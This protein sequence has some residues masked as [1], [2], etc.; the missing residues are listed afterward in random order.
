MGGKK[1]LISDRVINS[2]YIPP[3][4]SNKARRRRDS[5]L[6]KVGKCVNL[7]KGIKRLHPK[8]LGDT[9]QPPNGFDGSLADFD[10]DTLL[11]TIAVNPTY[12]V[13]IDINISFSDTLVY[14]TESHSGFSDGDAGSNIKTLLL[15]VFEK[16]RREVAQR[17]HADNLHSFPA[18]M[19]KRPC[20]IIWNIYRWLGVGI[21][22]T[23]S[24]I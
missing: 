18:V 8:S 9:W 20:V 12:K 23:M 6:E 7:E 19:T 16:G 5:E 21:I 17:V 15:H 4:S 11:V 2:G 10:F 3:V 22:W 1:T 14:F 13:A 24:W